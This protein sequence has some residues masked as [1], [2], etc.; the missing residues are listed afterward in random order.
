MCLYVKRCFHETE[1]S[2]SEQ[3]C[4]SLFWKGFLCEVFSQGG[5]LTPDS[6]QIQVES[7]TGG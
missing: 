4:R 6:Y 7:V 3:L 1:I 2:I 5:K